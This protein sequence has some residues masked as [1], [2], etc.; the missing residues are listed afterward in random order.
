[1]LLAGE[2]EPATMPA[3][4]GQTW[5]VT[6]GC[7]FIGSHL[8]ERLLRDGVDVVNIDVLSATTHSKVDIA[9]CL[10][11][12]YRIDIGNRE[13]VRDVLHRH[14]PSR[15]FNL[16]AETHVDRSIAD[17][18]DFF[19][20]NVD[21]TWKFVDE[22][23]R[24]FGSTSCPN[25]FMLVHVSTDEVY[26]SLGEGEPPWT[27]ACRL[28]PRNPYS[29]S[30]AASEHIVR[31]WGNT[32]GLPWVVTNCSNNYGP[33]QFKEKFIPNTVTKALAAAEIPIYGDGMQMREWLHVDDHVSALLSI[34][35]HARPGTSFNI[36]G[37]EPVA[38]L[39]ILEMIVK[40]LE[41]HGVQ[42]RHLV[43]HVHDRLG[44]DRKYHLD[45]GRIRSQLGWRPSVRM[46]DGIGST[47]A[48]YLEN[49][50][51]WSP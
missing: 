50:E 42:S 30:K 12:F 45:S 32:H 22:C 47:V 17:A 38:N 2:I 41:S 24:Y 10:G 9:P 40:S 35:T 51:W 43:K 27:E 3:H 21:A 16:A 19:R 13:A 34:G 15:I 20:T 14:R 1:M 36:G 46:E 6:G 44:H 23:T 48:W 26:G 31:A 28:N 5:L 49:R 39:V 8:V 29:A 4:T 25:D 18:G 33:R 37:D 11:K 7:G